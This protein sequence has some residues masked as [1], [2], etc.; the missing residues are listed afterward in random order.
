M[1]PSKGSM[2]G[3]EMVVWVP[4]LKGALSPEEGGSRGQEVLWALTDLPGKGRP[5]PFAILRQSWRMKRY[6]QR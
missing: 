3:G 6:G 4:G 5:Q 2:M 1:F